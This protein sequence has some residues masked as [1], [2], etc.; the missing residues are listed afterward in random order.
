MA[1]I[2]A[3]AT[4]FVLASCGGDKGCTSHTYSTEYTTDAYGH[5]YVST[6]GCEGEVANYGAHKDEDKNGKCDVCEY[7]ICAHTFA[8]EWSSDE[9]GHYYASTCECAPQKSN[10]SAHVDE[11]KD[12]V[13]DVCKYVVCSHEYADD[14]SSDEKNH[15][16]A[17][18]CGC[19]IDSKSFGAHTDSNKDGNCDI[20]AYV[21]CA[22]TYES[23]WSSDGAYHW[24]EAT[25]G[26][27]VVKD[28]AEHEAGEDEAVCGTCG[29]NICKHTYEDTL[30]YDD[31]YHWYASSCGCDVV[32]DKAE[33]TWSSA[34]EKDGT[35][36]WHKTE[37]GCDVIS[38]VEE[39]FDS[40]DEDSRCDKCGQIDFASL[41]GNIDEYV[42]EERNQIDSKVD[43]RDPIYDNKI[44][45]S[46]SIKIYDDYILV[47]DGFG[48]K[49]YISYCGPN[50]SIPFV[51]NVDSGNFA[52]RELDYDDSSLLSFYG[53]C[54]IAA[55]TS[56]E[57]YL[58]SL[59]NLGVSE[60][61]SSF[62][63]LCDEE[64]SKYSFSYFYDAGY[65]YADV[66][67]EFTLD[68]ERMGVTSLTL[69]E[70]RY[71]HDTYVPGETNVVTYTVKQTITQ[72]FG[73]PMDSTDAK[74]PYDAS[75]Y[76][77][78]ELILFIAEKKFDGTYTPTSEQITEGCT[79][80]IAPEYANGLRLMLGTNQAHYAEFNRYT[81]ESN[82]LEAGWTNYPI[83][84][85]ATKGGTYEVTVS[86]ELTSIS[87]TVVAEYKAPTT[88]RP[89]VV[90]DDEKVRVKEYSIYSGLEFV[91][92]VLAN[93]A[94]ESPFVNM[95]TV[96]KGDASKITFTKDGENWIA[97]ASE[98]GEYELTFVSAL[99]ASITATLP[100]TVLEIP[101]A[102]DILNGYYELSENDM[103][104]IGS[105]KFLPVE[106]GASSGTAVLKITIP[107]NPMLGM[108]DE[109]WEATVSY[110]YENGGIVISG[111]EGD[112]VSQFALKISDRYVLTLVRTPYPEMPDYI[113]EYEF[114]A[115]EE[116]II[117]DPTENPFTM[118]VVETY[119][120]HESNA[121]IFVAGEAGKYVFNVPA[122]YGLKV[123]SSEKVHY[124]NNVSGFEFSLDLKERQEVTFI[125]M[126]AKV[127]EVTM[128]FH[129]EKETVLTDANGL[130]G[131]YTFV[132]LAQFELTF[133][134]SE[135]GAT[136]GVLTVKDPININRSGSFS[137]T[138]VDGDY[139][140]GEDAGVFITK[141]VIGS[142]FFQNA[143]LSKPYE[144]SGPTSYVEPTVQEIPY[145]GYKDENKLGGIYTVTALGNEYKLII[146]PSAD[147]GASGLV[148]VYNP[149]SGK[150]SEPYAYVEIAYEY[151]F[152]NDIVEI[153]RDTN[154]DWLIKAE[155]LNGVKFADATIE[156][157]PQML[158]NGSNTVVITGRDI[159]RGG[160]VL[161]FV[162]NIKGK[163]VF[164]NNNIAVTVKLDG[165]VIDI[166][167]VDLEAEKTYT[168]I[169]TAA[170]A[171][172]YEIIVS[173][174]T[175][176]GGVDDD[177]TVIFPD[178]ERD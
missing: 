142:W 135:S 67:V 18:I 27:D 44:S 4:V 66:V 28:K 143:S 124:L 26:C 127:G 22:H 119:Q 10:E 42:G 100:L 109:V 114:F 154:G 128:Y 36:H 134:P 125:P 5:W 15:W 31:T 131:T 105:I 19:E 47:T 167:K 24:Y 104:M 38:S 46:Q 65:V 73:D 162:P 62:N 80:I 151:Y 75:K 39:H 173:R 17:P 111:T 137:Y 59:Y 30:S 141:D 172:T 97:V 51:V 23:E 164:S 163:Y 95:P 160:K 76:L 32:K 74:N 3:L 6:C 54:E 9:N 117:K 138:I 99:D 170:E 20:C 101:T 161:E 166:D 1:L 139:V 153:Y 70:K 150:Y 132:A 90:V 85:Y 174:D 86:N 122:G 108:P 56:L 53:V 84:M 88:L 72:G 57:E 87:F 155:G 112:D 159:S 43:E 63:Y 149:V 113:E 129:I 145:N 115:T 165:N 96:S 11:N 158:V 79:V 49:K 33:H 13:C 21:V 78:S 103:S 157:K 176:G 61:A 40:D 7:V 144:F 82:G 55:G 14:W 8:S 52:Q 168:V 25:C 140:F 83:F 60:N 41:I 34:W 121:F 106:A 152:D 146:V 16:K 89:A 156:P 94:A 50:N 120:Y 98:A 147:G 136:S 123:N 102:A 148:Q 91:V 171:S 12:G 48:N 107:G 178:D 92:G 37:C 71:D 93:S 116:V 29:A 35:G 77:F 130:G 64:N 126:A 169:I 175:S 58:I 2:L 68:E 110:A 133:T 118:N 81:V 177:G 45:T 69:D